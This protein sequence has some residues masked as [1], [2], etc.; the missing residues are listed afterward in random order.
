MPLAAW[1]ASSAASAAF[2]SLPLQL[3]GGPLVVAAVPLPMLAESWR[4]YKLN[5]CLISLE[6]VEEQVKGWRIAHENSG[7]MRF[8]KPQK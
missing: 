5:Y 8:E 1:D 6:L 4:K 2:I 3:F 7:T